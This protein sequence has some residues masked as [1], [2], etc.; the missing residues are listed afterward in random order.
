[1]CQ[2]LLLTTAAFLELSAVDELTNL[3]I[4]IN[5]LNHCQQ[6]NLTDDLWDCL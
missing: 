6:L 3:N 1:M 2:S 4:Y 5:D